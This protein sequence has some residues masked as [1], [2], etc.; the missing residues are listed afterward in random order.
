MG[1]TLTGSWGKSN[2]ELLQ[3]EQKAKTWHEWVKLV[4]SVLTLLG[5]AGTA[6][7]LGLGL[8]FAGLDRVDE[9]D[10]ADH[11]TETRIRAL[12]VE[13]VD[14]RATLREVRDLT[15]ELHK[16]LLGGRRKP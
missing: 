9:L 11:A 14:Q 7:V 4:A 1:R 6:L 16:S 10:A 8:R 12:E 13:M 2:G 15:R 5:L 3:S